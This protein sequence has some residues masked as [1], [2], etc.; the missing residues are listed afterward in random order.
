MTTDEEQGTVLQNLATGRSS[1]GGQSSSGGGLNERSASYDDLLE[2][3]GILMD[4]DQSTTVN[5][6]AGVMSDER[7]GSACDSPPAGK[8]AAAPC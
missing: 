4:F 2:A 6:G 3:N 7:P 8:P 5:Q 1:Q